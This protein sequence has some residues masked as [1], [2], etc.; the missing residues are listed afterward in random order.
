MNQTQIENSNQT[1]MGTAVVLTRGLFHLN[2]A[3]T[4]H[5]LVR[6]T[7]RFKILGVIDEVNSG[8]DAGVVLDGIPRDIPIFP[9][10]R[11]FTDAG[12]IAPDYAVI[13]VALC[14]GRLDEDWQRL[15]LAVMSQGISIVN[16]LHMP[17]SDIPAFKTAAEKYNVEIID[18]RRSKPFDQLKYWTGKVFEIATPRIAVL[19]TDCAVG[20]RTTSRMLMQ[21]CRSKGIKTEFIFT[22]QTGW[23]Q[24]SPYGFILDATPNDFV[25]GELE[26]AI[27]EC[28]EKSNPDLMILEGQ[29]ALRN[30][31][32]PCGAEF[33]VSAGAK[34]VI[35][36]HAPFRKFFDTVEAFGCRL[37]T[38]EDEI[39]LI[40]MYGAK[41]IAVTLNGEGGSR[42]DLI[43]YTEQLKTTTQLPVLDPLNDDLS[44]LLPV[45]R[46]FIDHYGTGKR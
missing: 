33:I 5:G 34:G 15:V 19:G 30:P 25:C 7:E 29:S 16:G 2:D 14:G 39:K 20:K 3:K 26:A 8:K 46:A 42:E 35:L 13:G 18:F 11:A 41:V 21:M 6:G 22:G 37:P 31:L 43:G 27:V 17:L 32:G 28:A 4:A 12:G 38:V 40:E 24:G 10:V 23:L 9:S 36:Q 45:V 1:Y 44:T